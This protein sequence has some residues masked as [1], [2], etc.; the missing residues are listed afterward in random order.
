[1]KFIA[2]TF[3][4]IILAGCYSP[5]DINKMKVK[6]ISEKKSFEALNSLIK[7][8]ST[9]EQCFAVGHEHIGEFWETSDGLWY[10]SSEYSRKIPI[11]K[12][13]NEVG[14]SEVRYARYMALFKATGSQRISH[15]LES[16]WSRIILNASGLGVSGCLT[17][18]NINGNLSI[19]NSDITKSYSSEITPIIEG[20]YINHDCT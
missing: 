7:E 11:E 6:F 19:P 9:G 10:K 4:L 13:L 20:W 14:I 16:G 5:P 1:M 15:C 12:V 2:L 3:I 17:S 18:I 8:D